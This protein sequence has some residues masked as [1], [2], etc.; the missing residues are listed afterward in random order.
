M[1][2]STRASIIGASLVGSIVVH[3]AIACSNGAAG[4]S[5][6]SGM[7]GSMVPDARA[8]TTCTQWEIQ[9]FVPP[10]FQYKNV[11]YTNPDGSQELIAMPTYDFQLPAGWEPI[12][13]SDF[14]SVLARHCVK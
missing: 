5:T 2:T 4:T 11:D 1:K 9:S 13:A 14:A 7:A 3:F 12:G 6:S 8:D 10:A